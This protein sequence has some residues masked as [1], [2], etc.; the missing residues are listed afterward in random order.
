M[1]EKNL[2]KSEFVILILFEPVSNFATT[3]FFDNDHK[4]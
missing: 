1:I 4:N 2:E 3:R